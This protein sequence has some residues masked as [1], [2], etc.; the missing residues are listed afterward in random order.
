LCVFLPILCLCLMHLLNI[1]SQSIKTS[2]P[3]S[4]V[5]PIY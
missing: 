2:Y 1:F 4:T 5:I 3:I